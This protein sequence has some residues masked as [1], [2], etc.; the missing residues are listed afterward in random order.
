MGTFDHGRCYNRVSLSPFTYPFERVQAILKNRNY[1]LTYN[2]IADRRYRMD[3]L[4]TP[5]HFFSMLESYRLV[6]SNRLRSY[7]HLRLKLMVL[8]VLP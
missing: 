3:F 6:Q 4:D 7:T 2:A 1:M 8:H 5:L